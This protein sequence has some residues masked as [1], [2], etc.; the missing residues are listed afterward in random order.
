MRRSR[1]LETR[2]DYSDCKL[3]KRGFFCDLDGPALRD[4]GAIAT[5]SAQ[6]SGEVLFVE[7]Q[8]PHGLFILCKGLIKLSTGSSDGKTLILQIAK[9]GDPIG[10]ESVMAGT[11]Y[12]VTA[13]TLEP[14]QVAFV[15]R[16]D[17]LNF[18]KAHPG[19]YQEILDQILLSYENACD[20]L[21]TL[22]LSSTPSR[23]ARVLLGWSAGL[24]HTEDGCTVAL[25]H[26]EIG[27]FIGSTRETV[28]RALSDFKQRRLLTKRGS[29]VTIHDRRALEEMAGAPVK[30]AR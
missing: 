9:P 3:R 21:R 19:V 22:A 27:E 14:C 4:F 1:N 2:R 15:R 8:P 18:V 16:R 30:P 13:E 17:F 28:T 5:L 24:E 12:Q 29:A 20:Q 23:L 26:G 10:L 25:T 11:C 6:R 7:S